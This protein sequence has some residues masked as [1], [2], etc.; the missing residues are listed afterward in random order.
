[1]PDIYSI[2][3]N[4][5]FNQVV[6]ELCVDTIEGREPREY[7]DEYKGERT[8]RTTSVGWREP[9]KMEVFSDTLTDKDGNALKLEDKVVEVAKIITNFPK[10][11]VRTSVAFMFGGRMHINADDL[12]D[13]VEEF[14]ELWEK[15][16][17]MHSLLKQFAR[18]VLSETKAA[19]VFYPRASVHWSGTK[20]ITLSAKLLKLPEQQDIE[21]DFFPHFDDNEDMDGF[22]H[23]TQIRIDNILRDKIVIWTREKM[24]IALKSYSDWQITESVNP[25]GLIPVVYADI[26]APEWD[27]VAPVMD[28]REMR[29]SRTA[30]TNDYFAEPIMKVFGE[31]NLPS[32]GTVG[33]ELQFPVE[34]DEDTGKP[35]HGDADFLDWQQSIDSVKK[36]LEETKNELFSGSSTPDLSFDNLKGMGNLSGV[37]RRFMTLDAQIKAS[38]NLETFEPAVQRCVSVVMAG[39]S[40]ITNIKYRSQ[41]V[42]NWISVTFDSILPKDPVED[43]HVLNI[44]GGGKA[45]NSRETIVAKSPLTAAGDV[46]DEIK[47]IEEDEKKESD[48]NNQIGLNA[49]GGE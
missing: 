4:E 7:L 42:N 25:F 43:A 6:T 13:G 35:I 12:N 20:T 49:F 30:D 31:S 19:I 21:S 29:L 11:I 44:A 39:I 14:K 36:E 5:D 38:E 26:L 9:K 15:K 24:I 48:R 37:A 10:K 46:E 22:I 2:L 41:L 23:K 33:K 8:R 47:R 1:M 28:A 3:E 27:E 18:T 34:Y 16:L 17:K 45:F 32:K 40:N